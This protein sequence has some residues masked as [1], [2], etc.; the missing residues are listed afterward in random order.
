[1]VRPARSRSA[2]GPGSLTWQLL[3]DV[4]GLLM[5]PATLL[6]QVA[7][8][9]V[10]AGVAQHSRFRTDP[11][12]RLTRTISSTVRFTYGT[13]AVAG[14]EA[15]RLR[16]LHAGI[17]GTDDRGRP[18]R[19]LDPAA[20]AWVHLTLAH[21]AVDVRRVLGR[22][23][24]PAQRV[25]FYAEWRRVGLR[26]GVAD[27]EMPPD[28]PAF[29][30]YFDAVLHTTLEDNQSVRDV[31]DVV[32]RPPAPSQRIPAALWDPLADRAGTL[33][34]LFTV[35]TLPTPM[36]ERLAL[37]WTGADQRRLEQRAR[38]VRGLFSTL[39]APLRTY[40]QV[41]P[42]VLEARFTSTG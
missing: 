38:V 4:R 39:P 41:L 42:H 30:D 16:R 27:A 26:L 12:R 33:Q 17:T 25:A 40:P 9:V 28:W 35:G 3:G 20:Y 23:L 22:P 7:H 13:D 31:L 21:F 8:P 2:P 24:T 10:G 11:W 5:A 34:T 36:R 19:A 29:L 6:L 37:A 32:R 15:A 18:Y 1:M 14:P